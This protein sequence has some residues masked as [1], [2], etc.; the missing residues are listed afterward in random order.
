MLQ[1]LQNMPLST[2]QPVLLSAP[3]SLVHQT[4]LFFRCKQTGPVCS[5]GERPHTMN[6]HPGAVI[7]RQEVQQSRASQYTL[8]AMTVQEGEVRMQSRSKSSIGQTSFGWTRPLFRNFLRGHAPTSGTSSGDTPPLQ[9]LPQGCVF[10][11]QA[12]AKQP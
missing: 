10:C 3:V 4:H 11:F 2:T 12:S 9:A 6:T 7:A 8:I 1:C 5:A